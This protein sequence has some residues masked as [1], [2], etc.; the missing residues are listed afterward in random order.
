MTDALYELRLYHWTAAALWVTDARS[1]L[2]HVAR[3]NDWNLE[4]DFEVERYRDGERTET[5]DKVRD[6]QKAWVPGLNS[7][8]WQMGQSA[9]LRG[10]GE[11]DEGT[12]NDIWPWPQEKGVILTKIHATHKSEASDISTTL[13]EQNRLEKEKAVEGGEKEPAAK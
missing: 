10:K 4:M 5:A 13:V 7:I 3:Q 8:D 11:T 6:A 2:L 9:Y 12:C 1:H